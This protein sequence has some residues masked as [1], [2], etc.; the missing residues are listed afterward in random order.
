M[1][2]SKVEYRDFSKPNAAVLLGVVIQDENEV[3]SKFVLTP[4][5]FAKV[6]EISPNVDWDT[7]RLFDTTFKASFLDK[8]I[9]TTTGDD[10]KK[11]FK[12]TDPYFL[13]Y[14]HQKFQNNYQFSEPEEIDDSKKVMDL[15]VSMG[16]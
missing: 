12:I 4:S 11:E 14:L 2:Y 9:I 5:K 6:K 13:E 1:R 15:L 16:N 10:G 8:G 3:T 7:F